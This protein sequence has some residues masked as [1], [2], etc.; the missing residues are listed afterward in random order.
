MDTALSNNARPDALARFLIEVPRYTTEAFV[1][2]GFIRSDQ[3]NDLAAI[4]GGLRILGQMPMVS[5][6]S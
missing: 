1:R 6:I 4:V 5:R 2:F 3:R